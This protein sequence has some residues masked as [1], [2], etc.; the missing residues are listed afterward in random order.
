MR[1]S[2]LCNSSLHLM[3]I[4]LGEITTRWW[5]VFEVRLV[6]LKD[7][8]FL[9]KKLRCV[10]KENIFA[11]KLIQHVWRLEVQCCK[12]NRPVFSVFLSLRKNPKGAG[13]GGMQVLLWLSEG[14][15]GVPGWRCLSLKKSSG[16]QA[17]GTQVLLPCLSEGIIRV[18]GIEIYVLYVSLWRN[19]QG[20]RLGG[21]HVLCL[22][23]SGE[24][25]RQIELIWQSLSWIRNYLRLDGYN[26]YMEPDLLRVSNLTCNCGSFLKYHSIILI[27]I[28]LIF[29]TKALGK[30]P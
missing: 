11:G 4:S 27:H 1:K 29:L 14:I 10:T 8:Y 25:R 22:C 6:D 7:I 24:Q 12:K 17:G 2:C 15:L 26:E 19:R 20:A 5:E 23:L 3:L 28:M 30:I 9:W 13:T 16:C 18:P 21:M